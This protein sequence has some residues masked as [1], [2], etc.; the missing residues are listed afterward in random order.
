MLLDPFSAN[1][2]LPL[3]EKTVGVFNMLLK[4]LLTNSPY[5]LR[6]SANELGVIRI[7]ST[8]QLVNYLLFQAV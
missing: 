8:S 5:P 6:I 3:L 2:D 7:D 4:H 1:T